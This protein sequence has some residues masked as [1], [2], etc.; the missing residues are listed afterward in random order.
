MQIGVRNEPERRQEPKGIVQRGARNKN[1]RDHAKD[2][3]NRGKARASRSA[4]EEKRGR[5][6]VRARKSTGKE[7]H[8][9]GEAWE[10]MRQP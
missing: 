6:E 7:K 1:E 9:Q 4:G 2:A 3:R 8:R 10:E 5:G